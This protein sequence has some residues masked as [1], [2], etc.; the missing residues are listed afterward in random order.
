MKY[1]LAN[2]LGDYISLHTG[3]ASLVKQRGLRGFQIDMLNHK[4][5]AM[6]NSENVCLEAVY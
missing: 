2:T 4:S 1:Q 6:S 3:W 5:A